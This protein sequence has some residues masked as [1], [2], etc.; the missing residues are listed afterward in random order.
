MLEKGDAVPWFA[1][2][3]EELSER[4]SPLS[5]NLGSV[6]PAGKGDFGRP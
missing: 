4:A 5:N 2:E 6:E 3:L 1:H